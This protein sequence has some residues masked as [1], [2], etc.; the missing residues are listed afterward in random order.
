[1]MSEDFDVVVVG[2]GF[3]GLYALHKLRGLGLRTLVLEAA[4]G[5]GGT[6]YWN[7]YPGAR[8]DIEAMYY[9]YSFSPEL[10]QEW[11]WQERYPAQPEILRYV[12]HVADRFDLRRD[13]RL[14]T[15]VV[16]ASYDDARGRWTVRTEGGDEYD[17]RY[18]LMATGNLS[19]THTPRFP[20]LDTFTGNVY[21]T[22]RW[23]HD[24]VDFTGQSV[25][26]I[27]TGSSGIQSIPLIAEQA[28]RLTVFQRTPAFSLPAHNRP[29]DPAEQSAVKRDYPRLRE[30]AR[31]SPLG[32]PV[33]PA[34]GRALEATAEERRASYEKGWAQGT[35]D[36]LASTYTDILVDRAANETVADFVREKIRAV[37]ADPVT[38]ERLCPTGFPFGSKRP[39]LDT[40]YYA[41]YNRDQVRLVDV[42]A[43]P[44][45]AITPHGVATADAE[46][47]VD[48]IV[49]ATGF[50]AMT[51]ALA[52]IDIRGRHGLRMRDKWSAGPSTYLGLQIA[53]FANLFLLTGP[54]SP[55]ALAN[56]VA[57]IEQQVDWIA[58]CLT[59]AAAR[60]LD[61]I[62]AT[63]PAEREW[64][65]HVNEAAAGT[66]FVDANSWYLGANV[67]GKPR[68]FMPYAGGLGRYRRRCDQVAAAGYEGFA[69]STAGVAR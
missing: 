16:A 50:D 23:P 1:M 37:V 52:A 32:I 7:R 56:Q 69:M 26:V 22:A 29:L 34:D 4:D 25:A 21:H 60:G 58:G 54:G 64:V 24:G 45:V 33:T 67:P 55:A 51:G 3:G 42:R 31:R 2:A 9:S 46:Y 11:E 68:V 14:A 6:W 17:T 10:E 49:L 63:E 53:G 36:G 65:A 40:N 38:A 27:G 48:S 5:I 18:C 57:C 35:L 8:V 39:C 41:T 59:Y 61:V 47:T 30:Q 62:E 15:R 20:G 13:I 12:E 43:T 44:I 19:V 28:V 66:V